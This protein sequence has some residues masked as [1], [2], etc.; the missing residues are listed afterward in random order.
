[1]TATTTL[2][3]LAGRVPTR[4]PVFSLAVVN[5]LDFYHSHRSSS[6][7]TRDLGKN[8]GDVGKMVSQSMLI[9]CGP[10]TSCDKTFE[11]AYRHKVGIFLCEDVAAV[12]IMLCLFLFFSSF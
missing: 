3:N 6:T 5:E 11:N 1:M 9:V 2:C 8:D 4:E 10:R 7:K 12:S